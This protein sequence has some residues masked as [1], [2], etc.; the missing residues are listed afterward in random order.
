MAIEGTPRSVGLLLRVYVQ[1]DPRNLAPVGAF[2]ICIKHSDVGD[3][4]LLVVCGERWPGGRKIGDIG[5]E[6]RGQH[7]TSR[8]NNWRW[9]DG[10]VAQLCFTFV[11]GLKKPASAM[12]R[13]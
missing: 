8:D 11:T 6:W 2:P 1:D 12:S 9:S 4:V 7:R 13:S 5:I 3:G 10:I